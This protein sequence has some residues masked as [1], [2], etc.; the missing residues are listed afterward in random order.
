MAGMLSLVKGLFAPG[1][2]S[3][4]TSA[5]QR[6]GHQMTRLVHKLAIVA[7]ATALTVG[8]YSRFLAPSS[9]PPST[10]E[11]VDDGKS[12]LPA[13][14]EFEHLAKT[15]PI[16]MYE[17]CLARYQ[18]DAKGFTATM[19]K[20]E[21]INGE[22]KPPR[23]P[24]EEVI[25]LSVRGDTPDPVTGKHCIEVAMWWESGAKKFLGSEIRG[26][27]YS[28][29]P[30]AEGTGGKVASSR[31]DALFKQINYVPPADPLAQGQSRYSIRDA[32]MYRGMLRTYDAWKQ[33]RA[34]GTLKTEYI[35]K[36]AVP[37]VEGRVCYVIDRTCATP[38]VDPFELGGAPI[39]DPAVIAR[40]GLTRVRV[41]IDAETWL[42]V[43]SELYRPDGNL[44]AAYYFRKPNTN[45]TFT[46]DTFTIAALKAKK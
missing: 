26:T 16:S 35:G 15:D 41:M 6:K 32:G 29:K 13:A 38:E 4:L 39:T 24:Q 23:E 19:V 36:L 21:R 9:P 1:V 40:D 2:E 25:Q 34:A 28:E 11:F 45:P 37:E 8:V 42:Q 46:A 22:P 5:P 33:R 44:L 7:T 43:G 20:K 30:G 12:V 27:L 17:K 3:K 31:P 18:R 14:D 10:P